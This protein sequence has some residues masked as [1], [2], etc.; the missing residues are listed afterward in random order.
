MEI[1][2]GAFWKV[3]ILILG[4]S[5]WQSLQVYPKGLWIPQ[6]KAVS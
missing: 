6:G 5:E 3:Y 2:M 1:K 4:S